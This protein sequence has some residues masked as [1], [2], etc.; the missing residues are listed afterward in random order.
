MTPPTVHAAVAAARRG[1]AVFPCRPGDKRP[2]VDRWEQRACADPDIVAR[3]WPSSRHNI[4]LACGPSG[5]VVVDLDTAAHGADLPAEWAAE[6]GVRDGRDVLAILAE[7]AGQPWPSTHTVTTPSGGLHL[8][9]RAP[10]GREI[11]NSAGKIGPRIDGRGRG[12]YVLAAGSIIGGRPYRVTD[13]L[14]VAPLPGWLADLA[15][16][17]RPPQLQRQASADRP[18][19]ERLRG[20]VEHVLGGQPGDRNGRLY[21]AACRAAELVADGRVDRAAAETVLVRAAVD[22]GLRGGEREAQ[23]T[24]ASGLRQVLR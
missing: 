12:G 17:A 1:W 15:A 5:L 4:G 11:R 9:F 21:W 14:P 6:P 18:V 7:R 16:P 2:A 3:R 19:Y 8:Y 22:A 23:Q 20:L 10:P 13:D 24:V